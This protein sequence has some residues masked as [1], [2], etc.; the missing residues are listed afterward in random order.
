MYSDGTQTMQIER[1]TCISVPL[2]SIPFSPPRI[3]VTTPGRADHGAEEAEICP[4]WVSQQR[5]LENNRFSVVVLLRS[6]WILSPG[7]CLALLYLQPP[8]PLCKTISLY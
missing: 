5:Q 7:R 1:S 2:L 3:P 8:E 6:Q 4:R